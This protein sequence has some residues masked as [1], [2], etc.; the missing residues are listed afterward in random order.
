MKKSNP[1]TEYTE[2]SGVHLRMSEAAFSALMKAFVILL[3]LLFQQQS[4]R[5]KI[6]KSLEKDRTALMQNLEVDPMEK[7]NAK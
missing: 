5:G 7:I 3:L 2:P 1:Q 6:P 4:N